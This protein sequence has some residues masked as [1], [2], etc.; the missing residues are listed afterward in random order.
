MGV[1]KDQKLEVRALREHVGGDPRESASLVSR[2]VGSACV[3]AVR[4]QPRSDIGMD[5]A[6]SFDR[7]P[8]SENPPEHSIAPIL[9]RPQSV[10]MFDA[11]APSREWALPS[12]NVVLDTD[13]A[14]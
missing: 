4:R 11:R 8:I 6:K 3:R 1:P 12:A 14:T 10:A 9:A 2:A 7:P 13:V 5:P